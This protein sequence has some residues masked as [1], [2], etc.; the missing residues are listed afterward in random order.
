MT[1]HFIS[2]LWSNLTVNGTLGG[3]R[4]GEGGGGGEGEREFWATLYAFVEGCTTLVSTW[5]D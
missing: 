4:E 5:A 1:C 2:M 3:G